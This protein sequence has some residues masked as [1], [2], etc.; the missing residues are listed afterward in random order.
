[1]DTVTLS[2]SEIADLAR[3]ALIASGTHPDN[4]T[5]VARALARAERDGIASHGLAQLPNFVT[6]VRCGKVDGH[7]QP[8]ATAPKPGTVAVDAAH[9]FAHP[10]ID[11]G[12]ALLPEQ[13]RH[14][15]TAVM[16]VRR[17]YNCG[18]VGHHVEHLAGHGLVALAFVNAPAAIAPRGATKGVLGTNPIACAVPRRGG[19]PIVIDQSA[20]VVAKS[21]VVAHA[22]RGEAIPEGWAR[23]ADGHPTTDP[24]AALKGTMEPAGGQKGLG[25]ALIVEIFAAVLTG[26]Q[27]SADAAPF[28]GT[29]GGP[30][31]TGQAFLAVDPAALDP[32]GQP[33]GFYE[34]IDRLAAALT[35]EGGTRLP[36]ERRFAARQRHGT[37]GIAV[38]RSRYD[39]VQALA[40]GQVET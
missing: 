33:E 31:G 11:A 30:P 3:Q 23:D 17:S 26:A 8:A 7:A 36:G 37:E 15:G 35:A 16:G 6:H 34:R 40:A 13:A 22:H 29:Q 20:S 32:D 18:V 27:V 2:E 19:D 25:Q 39:Q 21:E 14:Q 9:G 12:F 4:A 28:A 38:A 1:M 5:P 10:A 24:N